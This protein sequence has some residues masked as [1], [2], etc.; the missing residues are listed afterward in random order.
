MP[1]LPSF[2]HACLG[3]RHIWLWQQFQ[4]YGNKFRAA[5]NVLLFNTPE[6]W[7][8]LFDIKANVRKPGFY[9]AWLRNNNDLNT[10]NCTDVALHA[11]K[12][13]L[14]NLAFTE[15]SLRVWEPFVTK[16][17]DRWNQLLPGEKREPGENKLKVISHFIAE[18]MKSPSSPLLEL[19][20]C[21]KSRGLSNLME[22]AMPKNIKEYSKI[23]QESAHLLIIAGSDTTTNMICAAF[24]YLTHFPRA[25][26]KL[27]NEIRETFSS[28]GEMVYGQALL[29]DWKYLRACMDEAIRLAPAGPSEL[30]RTVLRG[31]ATIAGDVLPEGVN[32][33]VVHWAFNRNEEFYGGDAHIFRPERWI[34]SDNP[35]DGNPEE[36]VNRVKRGL[37]TFGKDVGNCIGEKVAR[38]SLSMTIARTLWRFDVRA[39]PGERLGERRPELGWGRRDRNTYMLRDAYIALREGPILQF[40]E[41]GE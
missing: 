13:R 24:F 37:H 7:N 31:G 15:R 11:K 30:E 21:L 10:L 26:A 18:H 1:G 4:V 6:A 32:V 3:D 35:A 38:L 41:R 14:L 33:G 22:L 39:A 40:K 2:Y 17:T 25:Y 12:R 28:P 20:L 29:T 36:E 34:V 5:P 16:H 23:V 8:S 27:V 9:D 19:I